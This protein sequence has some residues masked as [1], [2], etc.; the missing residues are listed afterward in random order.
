MPPQGGR[1]EGFIMKNE[2]DM[3]MDMVLISIYNA[4][5]VEKIYTTTID[6]MTDSMIIHLFG[7]V[8]NHQRRKKQIIIIY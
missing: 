6:K 3:N 5:A 8:G 4:Q 7:L 2:I 1:K